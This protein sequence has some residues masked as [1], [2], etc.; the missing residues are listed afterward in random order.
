MSL[1]QVPRASVGGGG[2]AWPAFPLRRIRGWSPLPRG[3]CLQLCPHAAT[4]K[5]YPRPVPAA[6]WASSQCP[7]RASSVGVGC[8]PHLLRAGGLCQ[9][10]PLGAAG[11]GPLVWRGK[12]RVTSPLQGAH[13]HIPVTPHSCLALAVA[14]SQPAASCLAL[15]LSLTRLGDCL[16]WGSLAPG[17]PPGTERALAAV[18]AGVLAS[19]CCRGGCR[20]R[21][22][23]QGCL[24]FFAFVVFVF[25]SAQDFSWLGH[26]HWC[27]VQCRS[28][29]WEHGSRNN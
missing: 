2:G 8:L 3:S 17:Q 24:P 14:P 18:R 11:A 29:A 10:V 13:V 6:H 15:R 28:S 21:L 4:T 9:A 27:S 23:W 1:L 5:C 25:L 12:V 26:T 20:S 22:S 19:C 7:G 16:L